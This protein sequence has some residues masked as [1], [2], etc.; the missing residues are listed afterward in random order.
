MMPD[1]EGTYSG[2]LIHNGEITQGVRF[3]GFSYRSPM[4]VLS[5]T[6]VV[7]KT[8]LDSIFGYKYFG[9]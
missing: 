2:C 1:T 8:A 6:D 5:D 4:V 3:G 7:L 9:V